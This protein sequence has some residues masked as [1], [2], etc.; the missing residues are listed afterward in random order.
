MWALDDMR[1]QKL[2]RF[3]IV[4]KNVM[5]L[6]KQAADYIKM[7]EASLTAEDYV[8]LYKNARAAWGYEARAYPAVQATNDDVVK[9]V[10]FYLFL[11][12]PLHLLY[13]E[14]AFVGARSETPDRWDGIF[15]A[16]TV[17]HLLATA[18]GI[19]DFVKSMDCAS[20]I[21]HA[22]TQHHGNCAGDDEV[23]GATAAL[24]QRISGVHRAD[25]GRLGV[26]A[27]A[28]GWGFPTCASAAR[29]R[30]LPVLPWSP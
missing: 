10:I 18:S 16:I 20:G 7:A 22:G 29:E 30:S 27:A 13:G 19:S 17:A 12:L 8:N 3:N 11:M 28:F 2:A 14:T 23:R 9:G 6:H 26:A 5:D 21:R 4:N 25:I 15:F 1:I 24:Q